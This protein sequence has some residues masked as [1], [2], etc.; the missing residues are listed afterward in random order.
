MYSDNSIKQM[1]NLALLPSTTRPLGADQEEDELFSAKTK[2]ADAL[3]NHGAVEALSPGARRGLRVMKGI[4]SAMKVTC[5]G[6][7]RLHRCT[8]HSRRLTVS[9]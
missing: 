3:P 2:R 9:H 5:C 6:T 1:L 4:R 8:F 7:A